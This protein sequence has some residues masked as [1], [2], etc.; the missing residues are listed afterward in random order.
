[1]RLVADLNVSS[2]C[3]DRLYFV[4]AVGTRERYEGIW[5]NYSTDKGETW[6][7]DTR[8]DLF[9][10]SIGSKAIVASVAVNKDGILGISWVD[11]QHDP[12]QQKNDLYFAISKDGGKSFQRPVRVTSVSSNPKT[13]A[14]ADVANKFPGG[15][16]YLNIATKLDGSFQVIWSDSRSGIFELQTCNINIK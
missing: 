15:G 4:R 11:A 2:P 6:S 8:I 16:H 14:N 9:E 7:T 12:A 5:L 10:K 1:M 3:R 13:N